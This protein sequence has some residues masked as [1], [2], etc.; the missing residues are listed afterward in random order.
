MELGR[1]TCWIKIS[2]DC[3]CTVRAS[4]PAAIRNKFHVKNVNGWHLAVVDII[5]PFLIG[6]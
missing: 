6:Y 1:S 5:C 3:M 4:G 2:E